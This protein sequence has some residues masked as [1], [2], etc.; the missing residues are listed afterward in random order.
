MVAV[1]VA[2]AAVTVAAVVVVAVAVAVA[3]AV[4]HC[5]PGEAAVEAALVAPRVSEFALYACAGR[6]PSV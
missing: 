3:V 1:A 5:L 4:V 2:V 6:C